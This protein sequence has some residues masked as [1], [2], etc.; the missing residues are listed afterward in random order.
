MCL[1]IQFA[2]KTQAV[3]QIQEK[4][5]RQ[6]RVPE[7]WL[8]KEQSCTYTRTTRQELQLANIWEQLKAELTALICQ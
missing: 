3:Q 5:M 2:S 7:K 8:R 4:C 6:L 1:T